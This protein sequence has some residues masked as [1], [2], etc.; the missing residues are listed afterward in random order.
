MRRPN[1][2]IIGIEEGEPIAIIKLNG[3]KLKAIPLKSGT[4]Q[5]CPLSPYLFNWHPACRRM[6][7]DPFLSTCT[8]LKCKWIKDLHIKLGTLKL[9]D[10]KIGK[11]LEHIGTKE[12]FLNRTP[13]A[14]ALRS[15]IEKWNLRILSRKQKGSQH[16]G[17]RSLP[18]TH[19]TEAQYPRYSKKSKS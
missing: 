13:T 11:T 17:K 5:G 1:L 15:K 16:I 12:N 4:R 6:K 19:Q 18:T 9:L 7:I 2:R 14:H 10:E 3:E 8:K